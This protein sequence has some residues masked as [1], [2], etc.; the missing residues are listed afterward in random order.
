MLG[1]SVLLGH[2]E[3]IDGQLG[4][5]G[6]WAGKSTMNSDIYPIGKYGV[7]LLS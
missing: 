3:E 4:R 5:M 6:S 2:T 7:F 1:S